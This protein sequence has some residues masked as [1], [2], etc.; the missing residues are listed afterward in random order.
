MGCCGSTDQRH[1]VL[2]HSIIRLRVHAASDRLLN[3]GEAL[4]AIVSHL[5]DEPAALLALDASSKAARA[6][7]ECVGAWRATFA[8][9]LRG[10]YS[11]VLLLECV[12]S[13]EL[14]QPIHC[15]GLRSGFT[16]TCQ[17]PPYPRFALELDDAFSEAELRMHALPT[18]LD[19]RQLESLEHACH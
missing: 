13:Y 19:P 8:H 4:G 9:F 6:A 12:Q 7:L 2:E 18:G 17:P 16:L 1:R 5:V 14:G 11:D 3:L 15:Q 10:M